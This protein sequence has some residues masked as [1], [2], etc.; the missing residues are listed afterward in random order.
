ML[1]WWWVSGSVR[2][3]EFGIIL[4][5][6]RCLEGFMFQWIVRVG[7]VGVEGVRWE[8]LGCFMIYKCLRD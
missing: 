4:G 6:L 2:F 5:I 8:D 1:G 7:V 3:I